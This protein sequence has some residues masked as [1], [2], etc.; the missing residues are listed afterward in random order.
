MEAFGR[1]V[2]RSAAVVASVTVITFSGALLVAPM[3]GG[4]YSGREAKPVGFVHNDDPRSVALDAILVEYS[5]IGA[6]DPV[7]DALLAEASTIGGRI[8]DEAFA[9]CRALAVQAAGSE[10]VLA[11][12]TPSVLVQHRADATLKWTGYHGHMH[13]LTV[14]PDVLKGDVM[15]LGL[16]METMQGSE[17]TLEFST[18]FTATTG[19]AI[20]MDHA[21]IDADADRSMLLVVRPRLIK[22]GAD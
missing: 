9:R 8:S 7:L 13:A 4:G 17:R 10:R 3:I 5:T 22:N 16:T 14:W 1:R 21:G 12:R 19:T 6:T 2:S 15:R 20:A 18:V 11:L